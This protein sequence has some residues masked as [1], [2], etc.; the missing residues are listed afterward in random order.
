MTWIPATTPPAEILGVSAEARQ[1]SAWLE[2]Q[3]QRHFRA[4]AGY[5][6]DIDSTARVLH[7]LLHGGHAQAYPVHLRRKERLEDLAQDVGRH[8]RPRI[9]DS[10]EESLLADGAAHRKTH[11]WRLPRLLS[12]RFHRLHAV[13]DHVDDR[14]AQAIPVQDQHRAVRGQIVRHLQPRRDA[15]L[16]DHLT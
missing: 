7:D 12:L 2:R 16:A 5:A 6:D 3:P 15:L 1:V 11:R 14:A 8:A 13:V 4:L 9:R 10:N